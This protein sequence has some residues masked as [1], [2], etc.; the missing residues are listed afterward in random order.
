[1]KLIPKV[2]SEKRSRLF[3]FKFEDFYPH[4]FSADDVIKQIQ[5]ATPTFFYNFV[6]VR[7]YQTL[8]SFNFSVVRK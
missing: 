1:M 2:F 5:I 8:L 4:H 7:H 6:R 3:K